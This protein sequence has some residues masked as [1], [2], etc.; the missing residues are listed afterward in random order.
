MEEQRGCVGVW[1]FRLGVREED[2]TNMLPGLGPPADRTRLTVLR[3]DVRADHLIVGQTVP[4]QLVTPAGVS[5][6]FT[7]TSASTA[8]RVCYSD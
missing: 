4:V 3:T 5:H 6:A 7:R 2:S 8:A 1:G